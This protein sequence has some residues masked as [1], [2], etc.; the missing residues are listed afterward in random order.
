VEESVTTMGL[1]GRVIATAVI[2]VLLVAAAIFEAPPA[3]IAQTVLFGWVLKGIWARGWAV[4]SAPPEPR[5]RLTPEERRS[6]VPHYSDWR[7]ASIRTK[8]MLIGGFAPTGVFVGVWSTGD[9]RRQGIMM[10]VLTITI[11][12]PVLYRM[13]RPL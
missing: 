10:S 5:G 8:V 7:D 13:L 6:L 1:R 9:S 11:G 4:P 12:V 2:V 3:F